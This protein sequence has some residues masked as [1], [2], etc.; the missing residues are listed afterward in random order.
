MEEKT[1][2]RTEKKS[3]ENNK[4]CVYKVLTLALM[5]VVLAVAMVALGKPDAKMTSADTTTQENSSESGGY[6]VGVDDIFARGGAV[7]VLSHGALGV[8]YEDEE[9]QPDVDKETAR[10]LISWCLQNLKLTSISAAVQTVSDEAQ[11]EKDGKYSLTV[12]MTAL[13]VNGV[14]SADRLAIY[15]VVQ[16]SD[17]IGAK[18]VEVTYETVADILSGNA[19]NAKLSLPSAKM[20]LIIDNNSDGE[21]E[22]GSEGETEKTSA[23]ARKP[24]ETQPSQS[25]E[26][27]TT[28]E[29]VEDSAGG[30]SEPK[31]KPT[32]KQTMTQQAMAQETTKAE[33]PTEK[34]N[35]LAGV[36]DESPVTGGHDF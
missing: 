3:S 7:A 33:T 24:R 19:T 15:A 1:V 18:L 12:P 31:T 8:A 9:D 35:A 23:E 2:K 16:S 29:C 30:D 22:S 6:S 11:L 34:P 36:C 26:K 17:E 20:L 28:V 4:K 14:E 25:R 21:E 32:E 27:S 5:S 13:L 10:K